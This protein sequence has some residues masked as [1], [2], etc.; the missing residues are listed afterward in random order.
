MLLMLNTD[1]H[2]AFGPERPLA[3]TSGAVSGPRSDVVLIA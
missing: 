1:R 3:A 2:R